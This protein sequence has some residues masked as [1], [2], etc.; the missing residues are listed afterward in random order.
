MLLLPYCESL[1]LDCNI[2]SLMDIKIGVYVVKSCLGMCVVC[3]VFAGIHL[4][5]CAYAN[6]FSCTCMCVPSTLA[7]PTGLWPFCQHDWVY[8][9]TNIVSHLVRNPC[10]RIELPFWH[11]QEKHLSPPGGSDYFAGTLHVM[12][13]M[14]ERLPKLVHHADR[15]P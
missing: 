13:S 7:M 8:G 10:D 14:A 11:L 9:P 6:F 3:A 2:S 1:G 15:S 5:V 12:T 4:L